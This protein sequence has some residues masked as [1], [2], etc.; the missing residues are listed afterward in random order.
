M[1]AT[2]L[3]QHGNTT[4]AFVDLRLI[5]IRLVTENFSTIHPPPSGMAGQVQ[6]KTDTSSAFSV[7]LDD[8]EN[9]KSL[10]I[11]LDY[12]ASLSAPSVEKTFVDYSSKYF[13]NF[14]I[15]RST[16]FQDWR[17]LPDEAF[18]AYFSIV[19]Q[20]AVARA[21]S[22]LCEAGLKGTGLPRHGALSKSSP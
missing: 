19:H 7:G 11:E 1:I 13:A 3:T 8:L 6:L 12:Q 16:G 21:E 4:T 2:S 9:P 22:T 5:Q 17:N 10:T 18:D 15:L 20:F 14:D